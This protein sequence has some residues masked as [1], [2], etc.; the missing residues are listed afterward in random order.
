MSEETMENVFDRNKH[1]YHNDDFSEM[2]KDAV[3]FFHGTPVFGIP[4]PE[5]F[6]GSG[7]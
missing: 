1:V 7:V 6:S 2:L 4:P 5:S 3:R